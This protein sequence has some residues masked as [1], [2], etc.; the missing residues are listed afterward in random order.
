MLELICLILLIPLQSIYNIAMDGLDL[1]QMMPDDSSHRHYTNSLQKESVDSVYVDIEVFF[2]NDE[3]PNML[4]LE[5]KPYIRNVNVRSYKGGH[6][7]SKS[8]LEN[9]K[10]SKSFVKEIKQVYIPEYYQWFIKE[11]DKQKKRPSGMGFRIPILF[12]PNDKD[13]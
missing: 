5:G 11:V 8:A 9:C 4:P 2:P 10:L 13:G 6:L 7:I 3:S 1:K 12:Y